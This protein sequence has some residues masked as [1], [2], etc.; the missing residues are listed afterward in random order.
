MVAQRKQIRTDVVT[1]S[2]EME[3]WL[4]RVIQLRKYGSSSYV[5][6]ELALSTP[7]SLPKIGTE[8]V[9]LRG[10]STP[11]WALLAGFQEVRQLD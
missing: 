11:L 4:D 7:W 6:L 9:Q 5:L 1:K 2:E 3:N 8:G 10:P